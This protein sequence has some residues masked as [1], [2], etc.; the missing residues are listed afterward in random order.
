MVTDV[1]DV[2][3][4]FGLQSGQLLIQLFND[5]TVFSVAILAFQ[6]KWIFGRVKKLSPHGTSQFSSFFIHSFCKKKQQNNV[7]VCYIYYASSLVEQ[8]L[9][10]FEYG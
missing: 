2:V 10:A 9:E 5:M 6:L 1:F 7:F 8:D 3:L 4:E